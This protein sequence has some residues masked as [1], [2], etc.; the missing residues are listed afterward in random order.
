MR[1]LE[2][3]GAFS[4]LQFVLDREGCE[5]HNVDPFYDYGGGDYE[6]DPMHTMRQ[7]NKSFGTNVVLHKC[8]LEEAGLQEKFDAIYSVSTIEHLSLQS[9]ASTLSECRRLLLPGGRVVLTIDLFLNLRPFTMRTANIWG[10]NVSAKWIGDQLNLE[11][12]E[13]RTQ[14]LYGYSDF[15]CDD[16]LSH[17]EDYSVNSAYPQL[18]Q[19]MVF[20]H[21][22]S[23]QVPQVDD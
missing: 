14:E 19:M 15:S 4:G 3:G 5:V 9:I 10:G 18:A 12:I 1:L 17:L 8:T 22:G 21:G 11:L 7:L 16:I 20:G 2:I 13:G 6:V 23:A